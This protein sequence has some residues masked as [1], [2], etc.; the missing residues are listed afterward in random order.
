MGTSGKQEEGE[1]GMNVSGNPARISSRAPSQSAFDNACIDVVNLLSRQGEGPLNTRDEDLLATSLTV[2]V[3]TLPRL[4]SGRVAGRPHD[5]QDV[6]SEA[7]ARFVQAIAQGRV[8]PARS[9]AGYLLT[10]AINVI[11]DRHRKTPLPL[12]A[13]DYVLESSAHNVD[14]VEAVAQLLDGIASARQIRQA[15]ARANA[16][17]DTQ[18]IAVIEVWLNLAARDAAAPT[19]REVAVEV[20][21]G[22]STV[23]AILQRFRTYVT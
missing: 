2:I 11:R 6:A 13:N 5:A 17:G 7:L 9:P 3:D 20:G 12:P 14:D 10:I 19:T 16:A 8:T 21:L 15:V 18:A 4:L 22:K 23:A 1:S